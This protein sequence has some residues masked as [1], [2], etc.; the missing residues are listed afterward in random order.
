MDMRNDTYGVMGIFARC[1]EPKA[2]P[3]VDVASPVL[4]LPS[5]PG[6]PLPLEPLSFCLLSFS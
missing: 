2:I 4:L 5:R 6:L 1:R 3:G